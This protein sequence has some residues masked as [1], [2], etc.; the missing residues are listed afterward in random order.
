MYR[1]A[2][3]QNLPTDDFKIGDKAMVVDAGLQTLSPARVDKEHRTITYLSSA[4]GTVNTVYDK[5]TSYDNRLNSMY[6]TTELSDTYLTA[7]TLIHEA[8]VMN[9]VTLG[10]K[11]AFLS[12]DEAAA[13]Q[14]EC[15]KLIQQLKEKAMNMFT[16]NLDEV[17]KKQQSINAVPFGT[18]R[19]SPASLN[20]NHTAVLGPNLTNNDESYV[21]NEAD[22]NLYNF[23]N[24]QFS[25]NHLL[26][27]FE[28][29]KATTDFWQK[30][31]DDEEFQLKFT[32]ISDVKNE[33]DALNDTPETSYGFCNAM[34]A[35]DGTIQIPTES[36]NRLNNK[37]IPIATIVFEILKRQI[38]VVIKN[39]YMQYLLKLTLYPNP[40]DNNNPT[41]NNG[42]DD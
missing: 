28:N 15:I 8:D 38:Y 11:G 22:P 40:V 27:G 25:L 34:L 42:D 1:I 39:V 16:A 26:M 3:L 13:S 35:G 12:K 17:F 24:G 20:P 33:I 41:S 31:K 18:D 23:L 9:V 14:T 21:G 6:L 5:L 36:I 4:I 10:S 7:N 32:T 37:T 29:L 2:K 30:F 19:N